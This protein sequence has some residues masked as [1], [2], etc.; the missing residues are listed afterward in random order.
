ML[1]EALTFNIPAAE[2]LLI[3]PVKVM[4]VIIVLSPPLPSLKSNFKP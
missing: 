1:V 3:I 4:F 2:A